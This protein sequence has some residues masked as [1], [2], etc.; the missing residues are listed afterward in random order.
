M[1][2][3]IRRYPVDI[4]AAKAHAVH[5]RLARGESMNKH[6]SIAMLL[7][8]ACLALGFVWG[9]NAL[10]RAIGNYK[11]ENVIRV[12]GYAEKPIQSDR[13]EWTCTVSCRAKTIQAA[14]ETLKTQMAQCQKF[15]TDA[16]VEPQTVG[17]F[18]VSITRK[19]RLNEK[20]NETN[21]VEEFLVSQ[22][23][24]V[25]SDKVDLVGK[26]AVNIT[27]LLDEGVE[28]ESHPPSYTCSQIEQAKLDL[29]AKATQNGYERAKMLAENCGGKIGRL[30]SAQQGVFQIVPVNSTDVSGGGIYDTSTIAKT[31]K[32]VATLEFSVEK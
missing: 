9:M 18:P 23:F 32:A 1:A 11:Q 28:L 5:D 27:R 29:L 22:T 16:G 4:Q 21:E 7:L 3:G 20:G 25:T 6:I 17:V 31:M 2:A 13:V 14:H 10:S 15:L 19:N 12:K 8:G 24:G 26:V 30:D